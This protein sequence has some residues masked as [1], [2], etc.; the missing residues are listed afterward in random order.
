MLAF[1]S[2]SPVLR[3][4]IALL[5]PVLALVLTNLLWPTHRQGVFLFFVAGIVLTAWGAGF[6]P[7]LLATIFSIALIDF[8][9]LEPREAFSADVLDIGQLIAFGAI[10]SFINWIESRR[11]RTEQSLLNERERLGII[12]SSI[13]DGVV[14]TDAKGNITYANLAAQAMSRNARLVSQPFA[15]AIRLKNRQG[16]TSIPTLPPGQTTPV[17]VRDLALGQNGDAVPVDVSVA[18][19]HKGHEYSS[20]AVWVLHDVS[21]RQRTDNIQRQSAQHLRNVLDS[22]A[23]FVGVMTTDGTLVEMN[24]P[25]LQ[26][27]NLKAEDVIGKP[28]VEMKS[29]AYSE[30]VREQLQDALNRAMHGEIVRYDARVQAADDQ[31]VHVDFTLAP[32]RDADGMITHIIVSAVDISSRKQAEVERAQLTLLLELQRQRLKSILANVPGLVWEAVGDPAVSQKATFVNDYVEKMV[33]YSVDEWLTTPD[34]WQRLVHPD[35]RE[36]AVQ[37]AAEN[38]R[39][40]GPGVVQFRCVTK[41]GRSIHTETHST[42]SYDENTRSMVVRGVTMDITDR[43]IAEESLARYAEDLRRSNLELQQFAYIA[44]HDLQEPL[45]MVTSYLQLLEQRYHDQ[46]DDDAREFIGYAVDG[47]AR[48]KAL[49]QDL[50]IYSRVERAEKNFARVDTNAVLQHVLENLSVTIEEN[51]ATVTV[52]TLPVIIGDER[53]ITQLFQNLIS[54]AI[55]FHGERQPEIHI[56]A[57]C[58][59]SDWVFCVRDNGIGIEAQY[60]DR[61]FVIFQRLH[62]R[63]KYPGTGIGLAICKKVVERHGGRIWVESCPGEG[64]TFYFTIPARTQ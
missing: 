14:V 50:L 16:E 28:L 58:K 1:K 32:M 48:M 60:L 62:N 12:L 38:Y 24:R 3:W 40:G 9:L 5:T 15:A 56:G 26:L 36:K 61:I 13:A 51:S 30:P 27:S 17:R 41:D 18:P 37:E 55:K 45:R 39:R 54:N 64:T 46:L 33:G 59:G 53:Q 25:A 31:L 42:L 57:E 44:S 49:I 7:A 52:E 11:T 34:L 63:G 29:I 35:D 19:V 23:F 8:F 43:K 21:E 4:G 47:A 6:W 2:S 20:G 22:L 10:V